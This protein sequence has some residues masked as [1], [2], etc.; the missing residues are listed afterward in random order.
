MSSSSPDK[1]DPFLIALWDHLD[2]ASSISVGDDVL[3][4]LDEVAHHCQAAIDLIKRREDIANGP[5]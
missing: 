5:D 4:R 3:S 1:D 2:A